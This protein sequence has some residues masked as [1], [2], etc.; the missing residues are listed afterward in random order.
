MKIITD[1]PDE[2]VSAFYKSNI[3]VG[4]EQY[5]VN[6]LAANLYAVPEAKDLDSDVII[7]KA[8]QKATCLKGNTTFTMRELVTG[9]SAMPHG[10][11]RQLGKDF[12]TRLRRY[13]TEK[14]ANVFVF[15]HK[16]GRTN[17]TKVL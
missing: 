10:F 17:I 14:G 6:L 16:P 3:K 4:M 7:E 9:F 2:L 1:I 5:I 15:N 12:Q 8:L 13:N 11:R